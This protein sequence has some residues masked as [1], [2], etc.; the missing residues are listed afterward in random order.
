MTKDSWDINIYRDK[1]TPKV[2][3]SLE[4]SFTGNAATGFTDGEVTDEILEECYVVMARIVTLYGET[5]L[6][7][8]ERLHREREDRM[9]RKALLARV[10]RAW[11]PEPV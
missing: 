7:I 6:P 3:V 4:T 1:I 9:G 8:F 11:N 2:P 5:Y 10:A